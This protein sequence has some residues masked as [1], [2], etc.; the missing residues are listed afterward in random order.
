MNNPSAA[1]VMGLGGLSTYVVGFAWYCADVGGTGHNLIDF[2]EGSTIHVGIVYF[3]GGTI[4]AYRQG[5]VS[6][7]NELGTS[8]VPVILTQNWHYIEVKLTVDNSAGAVQVRV[9]G[10][11]CIN[12]STVDTQNGGTGIVQS[13][14][15]NKDNATDPYLD[16]IYV[17]DTLGLNNNDFIGEIKVETVTPDGDGT[18]NN[19]SPDT[20][21]TNYTQVDDGSTPDDD[22]TYVTTSTVNDS[23]LY[24]FAALTT[25]LLDTVH[26]V[27]V[28]NHVR[29]EDAGF[30]TVRCLAKSSL[31]T[32]EGDIKALGVD[33]RYV[34]HIFETDPNGGG[35]WSESSVNAAEFGIT[36]EA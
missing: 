18:T 30:R 34:D 25:S 17:C 22:T 5:S 8:T 28:R 32:N 3:P 23:D 12:V 10:V 29:K 20:G 1:L 36:I 2:M 27:C 24:T 13:I 15:F 9:D 33:Y 21:L 16:D 26:A 31:T 14:R 19:W 35:A 11:E 4:G 6:A 7:S